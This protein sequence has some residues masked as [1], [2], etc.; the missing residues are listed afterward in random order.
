[1]NRKEAKAKIVAYFHQQR[2]L[3][4]AEGGNPEDVRLVYPLA[5]QHTK[6]PKFVYSRLTR[7]ARRLDL[8]IEMVKRAPKDWILD[9]RA[10]IS[11]TDTS[12]SRG[13]VNFDTAFYNDDV[14]PLAAELEQSYSDYWRRKFA[15]QK[16]YKVRAP[17][18]QQSQPKPQIQYLAGLDNEKFFLSTDES[19]R[20]IKLVFRDGDP[21]LMGLLNRVFPTI[22]PGDQ[23]KCG[24]SNE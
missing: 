24:V 2:D 6:H 7:D 16:V 21:V 19:Y 11:P 1:M 22:S 20:L 15:K 8:T 12:V 3:M 10:R 13:V 17:E 9:G 23:S 14:K 4:E 5:E 18:V